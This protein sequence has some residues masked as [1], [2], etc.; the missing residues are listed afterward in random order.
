M[1]LVCSEQSWA[2]CCYLQDMNRF[3]LRSSHGFSLGFGAHT[4]HGRS[5]VVH[6]RACLEQ[7]K[8]SSRRSLES[9]IAA[10]CEAPQN[11]RLRETQHSMVRRNPNVKMRAWPSKI[12]KVESTASRPQRVTEMASTPKDIL[13]TTWIWWIAWTIALLSQYDGPPGGANRPACAGQTVQTDDEPPETPELTQSGLERPMSDQNFGV[14]G[15]ET[16]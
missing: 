13:E 10:A 14:S 1:G 5:M 2:S 8:V 7:E 16:W 3:K 12:N 9:T 11:W 6:P 4:P 15:C